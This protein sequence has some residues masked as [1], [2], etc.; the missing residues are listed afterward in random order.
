MPRGFLFLL[1]LGHIALS[2]VAVHNVGRD[3]R[4][5][6]LA[7][8]VFESDL[9][10]RIGLFRVADTQHL[11]REQEFLNLA[12][13]TRCRVGF[14]MAQGLGRDLDVAQKLALLEGGHEEPWVIVAC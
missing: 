3:A 4:R 9:S 8:Q 11:L 7:N 13:P 6:G 1:H 2:H 14:D 12:V 10:L 5:F